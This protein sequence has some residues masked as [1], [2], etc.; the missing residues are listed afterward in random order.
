MVAEVEAHLHHE[1][2]ILEACR[3]KRLQER[4]R[5]QRQENAAILSAL[6]HTLAQVETGEHDTARQLVAA[7]TDILSLHRISADLALPRRQPEAAG[8]SRMRGQAAR[9]PHP[10]PAA[11]CWPRRGSRPCWRIDQAGRRRQIQAYISAFIASTPM[12]RP[13]C[14]SRVRPAG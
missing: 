8:L 3:V 13:T 2:V 12:P 6:H 9:T 7:L 10:A 1:E 11:R 14:S 4:V 5:E